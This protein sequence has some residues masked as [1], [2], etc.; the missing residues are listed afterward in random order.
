LLV[1]K[2]GWAK[3][4]KT[5]LAKLRATTKVQREFIKSHGDYSKAS[6][7]LSK[8][9]E[10]FDEV[11]TNRGNKF[12][13]KFNQCVTQTHRL[14]SSG[15]PL[16][17][18]DGKKRGVQ[19]QNLAREY[20]KLF[21]AA[22]PGS[23]LVETDGAQ[24]EFRVAGHL[25]RDEQVRQDVAAGADIHRFTA[26]VFNHCD[27]KDV[28]DK[29]RTAAKAET[30]GPLYGRTHG[31]QKQLEYIE[32]F[33]NKYKGV[34]TAQRGWVTEVLKTQELRTATGLRF[35]FPGTKVL[36]NGDITNRTNIFNYPIQSFATADIIPISLVYTFWRTRGYAKIVNTVHDSVVAEVRE[37]DVDKYVDASIS[38]WGSDT[39]RY[40]KD[41]YGLEMF[42]PL[43]M[44]AKVALH[45]GDTKDEQKFTLEQESK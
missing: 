44:G 18:A 3:T 31:S 17:C 37:K 40:L 39:Y 5:T 24:L 23:V 10:F 28:T 41:V 35:Y 11:C 29:Q 8:A 7:S 9:L 27:E 15:R 22:R 1:T 26:S 25:G 2:H 42:V 34:N 45:W 4:D 12:Y 32:A 43:G 36:H 33:Q 6:A 19:F 13:G 21:R 14:S 38:C 16:K 30:F 20:K